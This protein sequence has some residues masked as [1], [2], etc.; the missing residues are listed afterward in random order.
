MDVGLFV[1][2]NPGVGNHCVLKRLLSQ[3]VRRKGH[4]AGAVDE[5]VGM[6]V[7]TSLGSGHL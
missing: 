2:E 4:W 3:A 7:K 6:Q 1:G 5:Q